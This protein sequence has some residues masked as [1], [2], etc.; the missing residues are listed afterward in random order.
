MSIIPQSISPRDCGCA[1][2]PLTYVWFEGNWL[3]PKDRAQNNHNKL[4][5]ENEPSV[6][7]WVGVGEVQGEWAGGGD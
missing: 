7:R 5:Q 2:Q 6:Y 3:I 1:D 4:L